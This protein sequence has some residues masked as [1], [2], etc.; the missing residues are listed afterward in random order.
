MIVDYIMKDETVRTS[1]LPGVT[2][3]YSHCDAVSKT[4]A[5]VHAVWLTCGPEEAHLRYV[6]EGA[7]HYN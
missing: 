2:L 1:T 5:L 3:S 7:L 4:M 6:F